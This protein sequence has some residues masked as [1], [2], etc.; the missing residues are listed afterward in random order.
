MA[1]NVYSLIWSFTSAGQFAQ[2]VTH[3]QFDDA[4]FSTTKEAAEAL[5]ISWVS[6]GRRTTLMGILPNVVTLNSL[7]G[8]CVSK[9]GGFEAF[10]PMTSGNVGTRVG[11]ISATG[12]APVI[13]H[14]PTNLTVGRGRTFL[15]GVREADIQDGIWTSAYRSA[16][17]AALTTLFDPIT[18]TGGGGP[19]AITGLWRLPSKTFASVSNVILS[20]NVGT[21]RRRMRPA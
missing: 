17:E 14:Y 11:P 13:V 2:N 18:L 3:W 9:P 16:V 7:K 15:P 1:Q 12:I 8:K 4:G 10:S 20:E 19:V 5:Q 21:M 6:A